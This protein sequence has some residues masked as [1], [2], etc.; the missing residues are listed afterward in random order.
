MTKNYWL[1]KSEPETY[2]I[3]Q[4]AK[5]KKTLWS[6]VRNYQARN[7]MVSSMKPGDVFFFY[8]SSTDPAGIVGM[9]KI[10]KINQVDPTAFDPKSEYHD[11]K[12]NKDEPTWYCAEVTFEEKW[13]TPLT[14]AELKSEKALAKMALLQRGQR[15]SIQPV[16]K[17]EF[18]HVMKMKD[19]RG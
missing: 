5:D 10:A 11:P 8:H 17:L 16:T 1:M 18:D 2:S 12:S 4:F 19:R 7:Y 3:D 9:G 14:L 15:L 6:G 13:K